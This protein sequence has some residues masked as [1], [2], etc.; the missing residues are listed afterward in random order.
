MLRWPALA[1]AQ[2]IKT[3]AH[4]KFEDVIVA[5]QIAHFQE[6]QYWVTG[7]GLQGV[8]HHNGRKL[9]A[10]VTLRLCGL[11]PCPSRPG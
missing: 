11:N 1:R 2:A 9:G 6:L 5:K 10:D 7:T 4:H 8:K 3:G